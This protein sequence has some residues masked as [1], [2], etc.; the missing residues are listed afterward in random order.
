MSSDPV[1]LRVKGVS[2]RFEIYEHPVHRLLQM[3]CAGRKR[4][5]KEFWALRDISF[6]VRRGECVGIIGRN[7]AG[8]STL[9]QIITGTLQPTEGIVETNG[10]VAALLELGSGFNP[11]FTGRENVYMNAAILG[12]SKSQTDRKFDEIAEFADIGD[13]IDQPVKTYS[14]GMMVRLAFAVQVVVEPEILIV[15]EALAVG[16]IA[17]QQKC[18]ERIKRL[19]KQNVTI[20]WVSHDLASVMNICSRALF[21]YD[22]TLVMDSSPND[23]VEAYKK[24]LTTTQNAPAIP[25]SARASA[26]QTESTAAT[27]LHSKAYPIFPNK[28]EYGSRKIEIVDWGMFDPASGAPLYKLDAATPADLRVWLKANSHADHVCASFFLKDVKGREIAGIN[29]DQANRPIGSME[30]GQLCSISFRQSFPIPNGNYIL[31]FGC[32]GTDADGKLEAFHRIY[33]LLLVEVVNHKT[34]IGEFDL[35]SSVE[36]AKS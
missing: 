10:R 31:N 20:L 17:F 16:D 26:T 33:D 36:V 4:F 19:Q 24:K 5:F 34:F 13:F 27:K 28:K 9:L 11:E 22:R 7:G 15:D 32:S 18:Y 3:L 25:D 6:E 23:V 21:L 8:K 30:T 14:S 12:F 1:V 35:H 29:T 2:K